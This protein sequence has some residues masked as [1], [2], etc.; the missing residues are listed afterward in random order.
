MIAIKIA[1]V[2]IFLSL[3]MYCCA[4][5]FI[6]NKTMLQLYFPHLLIDF[7]YLIYESVCAIPDN[8]CSATSIA[9]FRKA[10]SLPVGHSLNV[11][12]A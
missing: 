10:Q 11:I 5:E 7:I 12:P 3:Y 1:I 2:C 8:V 6:F 9:P 4:M